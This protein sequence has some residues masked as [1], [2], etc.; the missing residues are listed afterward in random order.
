MWDA[1]CD[2]SCRS[3]SGVVA[4]RV[5]MSY[6]VVMGCLEMRYMFAGIPPRPY[7]DDQRVIPLQVVM[8]I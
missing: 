7:I 8:N 3:S 4:M 2:F 6:E 5:L 1:E